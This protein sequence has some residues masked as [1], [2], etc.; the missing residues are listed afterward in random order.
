MLPNHT[1]YVFLEYDHVGHGECL[2]CIWRGPERYG[3]VEL[4]AQDCREHEER[5]EDE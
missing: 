4:I 2:D 3:Y 1:A 5:Y